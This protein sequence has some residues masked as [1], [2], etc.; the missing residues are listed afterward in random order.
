[1]IG[2]LEEWEDSTI[3]LDL[4]ELSKSLISHPVAITSLVVLVA[5]HSFF[6]ALVL[7]LVDLSSQTLASLEG[8]SFFQEIFFVVFYSTPGSIAKSSFYI[9][10][11]L[12]LLFF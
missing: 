3:Q 1:M 11:Y 7:L 6:S 5:F 8:F 12:L 9:H 10:H 4:D 2:L